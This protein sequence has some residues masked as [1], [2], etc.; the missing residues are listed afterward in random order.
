MLEGVFTD[1]IFNNGKVIRYPIT[2]ENGSKLKGKFI[3]DVNEGNEEHFFSGHYVFGANELY[4]Y[5]ALEAIIEKLRAEGLIDVFELEL[6]DEDDD[7]ERD[8]KRILNNY[9]DK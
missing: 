1:N 9:I 8:M 5:K 2:F 3:L 6:V 4:I 7:D